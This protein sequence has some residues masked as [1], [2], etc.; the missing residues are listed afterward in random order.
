LRLATQAAQS[1]PES[2]YCLHTLGMAHYRAGDFKAAIKR[3]RESLETDLNWGG[4]VN[5]WLGLALAHRRL[6]HTDE[7]RQWL[8]KAVLWLDTTRRDPAGR[9]G[10]RFMGMHAHDWLA[11]L[12]LRRE[13]EKLILGKTKDSGQ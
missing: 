2:A 3:L 6:G 10:I 9:P 4:R 8:E 1:N 11:S 7:A 12:I 13:A 5:N